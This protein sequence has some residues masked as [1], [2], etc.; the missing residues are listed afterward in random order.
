MPPEA[1]LLPGRIRWREIHVPAQWRRALIPATAA[2]LLVSL[3]F[4]TDW[5]RIAAIAWESST[6]NHI[7]LI[8]AILAWMVVQRAPELRGL[9]PQAWWPA[10]AMT[11]AGTIVWLLGAFSGLDLARQLGAVAVLVSLVPLF[12]GLRVTAALIFPLCYAFLLVPMGEE[13]VPAL[14][15][16]T[17]EITIALVEASDI[18]ALIEGVF[19]DTPA[20]L[21]EVAEACSGV[22]FL[23]AMIALGLLAANVCFVS[24]KRRLLFMAACIAVPILANGVRAFATIWI[25]QSIGAERAAGIDHL[26][27]GWVFFALVVA[28]VLA[29][30]WPFFDRSPTATFSNIDAISGSALFERLERHRAAP[31]TALAALALVVGGASA[32]A[33]AGEALHADL[34]AKVALPQVDGWQRSRFPAG[35]LAWEPRA[36]GADRRLS[37]RYRDAKGRQVDVFLALYSSQ[38]DGREPGGFGQGAMPPESGW[39]WHSPGP[40]FAQGKSELLRGDDGTL[41]LAVTW[42]LS[43]SLVTGSNMKLKLHSMSDKLRLTERPAALMIVSSADRSAQQAEQSIARFMRDAGPPK[44]WMDR[45]GVSE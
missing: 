28:M 17:A 45:L 22:K 24:W 1:S 26:V 33:R 19:I 18:P 8:P 39:S 15:L 29:A 14:Q 40:R 38:G 11:L 36:Q 30:A 31:L 12:F 37:G 7:L 27:Y 4:A 9:A 10:I 21:F 34:P 35:A 13:L 41:R 23:I 5:A 42:Y 44:R 32:W 25:A 20:G 43:G 16:L 2:V 6:Y 3:A